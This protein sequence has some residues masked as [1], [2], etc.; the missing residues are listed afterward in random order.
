[1]I[2]H[3]R[4]LQGYSARSLSLAAG[5]SESYVGKLE[6]GELKEI[7]LR[8]FSRIVAELRLNPHEVM[9]LVTAAGRDR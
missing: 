1:M 8:S 9:I 4:E 6:K 7:S 5:L 3:M 2:R